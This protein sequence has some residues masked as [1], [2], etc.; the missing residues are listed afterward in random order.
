MKKTSIYLDPELDAAL[1]R[2]ADEEG[3]TKAELI[4]RTLAR[5]VQP[6]TRPPF[7]GIGA[8]TGPRDLAENFEQYLDA[9]GFGE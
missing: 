4:R 9:D 2:R 7:V 1:A 3:L 6:S 8:F 5:S